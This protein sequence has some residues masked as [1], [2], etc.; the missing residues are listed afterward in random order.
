MRPFKV[1]PCS[2]TVLGEGIEDVK[3]CILGHG[4]YILADGFPPQTTL[5]ITGGTTVPP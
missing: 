2:G 5:W 3:K 1:I 4:I